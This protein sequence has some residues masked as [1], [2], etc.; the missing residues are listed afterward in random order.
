LIVDKEGVWV[1]KS[2]RS[3]PEL[4]RKLEWT[5][6]VG[7]SHTEHTEVFFIRKMSFFWLI[8]ISA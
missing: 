6:K 1:V 8:I 2:Q 5:G 3:L 7:I 4:L